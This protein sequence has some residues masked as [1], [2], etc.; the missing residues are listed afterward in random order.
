MCAVLGLWS[1]GDDD[2]VTEQGPTS[3]GHTPVIRIESAV[4]TENSVEIRFVVEDAVKAVYKVVPDD[5]PLPSATELIADEEAIPVKVTGETVQKSGL[6]ANTKYWVVAAASYEE[7]VSGLDTLSFVTAPPTVSMTFLSAV[8][9]FK[10]RS[11]EDGTATYTI[12]FSTNEFSPDSISRYPVSHLYVVLSGE[13]DNV[14]LNDLSIPSGTYVLGDDAAPEAGKFYAGGIGDGGPHGTY[15]AT[16]RQAEEAIGVDLISGGEIAVSPTGE[17]GKYKAE[18]HFVYAD[19]TKLEATYEGSLVVDNASG[20][21]PPSDELPLPES[22]LTGDV[23]DMDITEGYYNYFGSERYG[24]KGMDE[25]YILLYKGS[26]YDEFVE[27]FLLVDN[28]KYAGDKKLPVGKYPVRKWND[29]NIPELSAIA[30][31]HVES[32]NTTDQNLGCQYTFN[33]AQVAPLVDG[34]VEVISCDGDLNV[35][36]KF[37]LKDNAGNPHTVSGTFKGR[38]Q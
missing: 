23:P 20:E 15:V 38:L 3:S 31:Y 36:L 37:T 19:G 27:L 2:T 5:A 6:D 25:I 26:G 28:R 33:Y 11:A 9:S 13:A 10:G 22:E 12:D 14:D 32:V 24:D 30:G 21:V 35:E 29:T 34:E 17:A 7:T 16:Q 18:I 1:C 4:A 8:G